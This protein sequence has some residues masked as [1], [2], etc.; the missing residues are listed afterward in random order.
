MDNIKNKI[1]QTPLVT[2]SCL[3]YNQSNYIKQTL[4]S[5]LMQRT[6]FPF[7]ILVYDDASNDGTRKIIEEYALNFPNIIKPLLQ[8]TNKYSV[9]GIKYL[10]DLLLPEVKG[11]Y[12][13]V[14]EGDDFWIDPLKLQKQVDFL[15]LNYSYGLIHTRAVKFIQESQIF[16]GML[17]HEV[18]DFESLL[19]ENTIANLTTCYRFCLFKEYLVQLTPEFLTKLT[20][21]DFAQ[22]LWFI[23]HSK[24]KFIEDITAVYRISN[25]SMSHIKDDLK[26]LYFVE[27]I[28]DVVDYY[29]SNS[30]NLVNLVNGRKIRA[31]YH[32][33]MIIL[34]FTTRKWDE[35]LVSAKVFYNAKDWLNLLWIVITLPFFYSKYMVKGSYWF[36]N[37]MFKL[38]RIYPLKK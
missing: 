10:Y 23:Q 17:G 4:D 19:Y 7:E 25:S 15:E 36:R 32:S 6:T 34:Y 13:A 18:N 3:T 16:K 9:Y 2:I 1:E 14:C 37:K 11:K 28:Y 31:R 38:F 20:S 27:G 26:R 5:L 12:L 22:W 30:P 35:I 24:I 33:N 8:E 29:L 21:P